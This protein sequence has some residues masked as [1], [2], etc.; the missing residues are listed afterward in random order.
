MADGLRLPVHRWLP[1][2]RVSAVFVA[3]HG[4][5]NYGGSFESPAELWATAGIATYAP[6]QRG[7]GGAGERGRW[8]GW[9]PMAG[10]LLALARRARD[11]HPG[12]PVFL[13]G[14]SM[15][16]A[17]ATLAAAHAEPDL[18]SGLVLSAPAIWGKGPRASAVYG[19]ARLLGTVMPG[20]TVPPL[21]VEVA[22]TDDPEVLDQLRNDPLI[23]HRTRFDT[24]AGII[25][26]MREA[27]LAA[28]RVRVPTL[29]LLGDSDQHVPRDGVATLVEE[30][31]GNTK[32]ALY[33]EGRH[34]LMRSLNGD[35]VV[36]D[37]A[38]WALRNERL[39]PSRADARALACPDLVRDPA[40][41]CAD[42]M[43]AV[44]PGGGGPAQVATMPL[45]GPE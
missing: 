11:A 2:G 15:G 32:V 8:Y 42:A 4:M 22:S 34:L 45:A 6:D 40:R 39:L 17:V 28:D 10:D 13:V 14:E 43:V 1:E 23:I 29:V 20:V 30:L 35:I 9:R 38:A 27:R 24:L 16:G 41:P 21:A 5:N 19:L 37:I 12:V 25:A 33:P 44:G 18:L 31:P 7:F 36:S 26:M 3:A